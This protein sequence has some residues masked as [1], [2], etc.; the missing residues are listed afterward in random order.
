MGDEA[1]ITWKTSS[2]KNFKNSISLF[3]SF[4]KRLNNNSKYFHNEFGILP[5]FKRSIHAGNVM[6]AEVGG[7][8]KLRL[9]IM[10]M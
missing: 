5:E 10:A 6:N 7:Y 9:P 8:K 4:T 1:V 3:F 2:I